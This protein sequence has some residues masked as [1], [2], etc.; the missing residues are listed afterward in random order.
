MSPGGIK[1]C[2]CAPPEYL[3]QKCTGS[4]R[5]W[6]A[7]TAGRTELEPKESV[8]HNICC[9]LPGFAEERGG[10]RI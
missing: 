9:L 3:S 1:P 7:P 2:L 10:G 4:G 6:D 8:A 5:A